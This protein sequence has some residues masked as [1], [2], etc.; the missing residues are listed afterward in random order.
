MR[1]L[2]FVF[3]MILAFGVGASVSAAEKE[4]KPADEKPQDQ[5]GS[6]SGTLH[7]PEK[8][9]PRGAVAALHQPGGA[10]GEESIF[11]LFADGS[12]EKKLRDLAKKGATVTVSGTITKDGY[13]VTSIS[14]SK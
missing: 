7:M 3:P 1:M 8:E 13:R 14:N 2:K 6:I 12:T 5:T 4:T 10:K 9:A 11:F